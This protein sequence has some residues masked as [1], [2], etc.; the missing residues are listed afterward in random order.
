MLTTQGNH[1]YR[2]HIIIGHQYGRTPYS[3]VAEREYEKT[4]NVSRF[5]DTSEYYMVT[6]GYLREW[7]CM[8]Q[9]NLYI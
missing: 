8:G 7:V 3:H 9:C 2:N 4:R 1:Y 5:L 6:Q